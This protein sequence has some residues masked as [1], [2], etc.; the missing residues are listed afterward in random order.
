MHRN[1]Q[2]LFEQSM[3]FT[4]FKYIDSTI[5]P[6]ENESFIT[7][8]FVAINLMTQHKMEILNRITSLFLTPLIVYDFY[9]SEMTVN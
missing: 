8:S 9:F 1:F 7:L 3:E 5:N 2:H 6:S 4:V